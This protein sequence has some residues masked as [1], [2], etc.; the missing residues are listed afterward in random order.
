MHASRH[1][2]RPIP[3]DGDG[4]FKSAVVE[5]ENVDGPTHHMAACLGSKADAIL[6]VAKIL[7]VPVEVVCR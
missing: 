5:G 2:P 3:R 6:K 4:N 7:K 1:V